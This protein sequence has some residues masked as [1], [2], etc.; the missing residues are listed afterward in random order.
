MKGIS[1]WQRIDIV[2]LYCDLNKLVTVYGV[3]HILTG[4][5]NFRTIGTLRMFKVLWNYSGCLLLY[6]SCK[7][8]VWKPFNGSLEDVWWLFVRRLMAVC[9]T[10]D[11]F[12]ATRSGRCCDTCKA[13]CIWCSVLF[14]LSTRSAFSS[15]SFVTAPSNLVLACWRLL[16]WSTK[17]S[18]TVR[19]Y[20]TSVT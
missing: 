7:M 17:L 19:L 20:L 11:G 14:S 15:I 6:G 4:L 1:K 13:R 3:K 9:K 18:E 8:T 16:T 5:D 12:K 2:T 10:F